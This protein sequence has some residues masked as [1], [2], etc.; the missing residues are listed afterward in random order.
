[1]RR[2]VWATALL[3]VMTGAIAPA[4]AQLPGPTPPLDQRSPA[5]TVRGSAPAERPASILGAP[6]AVRGEP[7]QSPGESLPPSVPGGEPIPAGIP[8]AAGIPEPPV[9]QKPTRAAGLGVPTTAGSAVTT[10]AAPIPAGTIESRVRQAGGAS[11]PVS[12]P[13]NEFLRRPSFKSDPD[14]GEKPP[15][16]PSWKL[17]DR[18]GE[19]LG[20]RGEW[21]R[22]DHAFDG[23]ISPVTNP[24]LFEDPRSLT[25][26]RPIFLS[27]RIPG[28]NPDFSGG[29]ITFFGA[30]ARLA[31]TDRLSFTINKLG[32]VWIGSG[33]N[34]LLSG[35]SGFS[36]LW[37]GPK[38]TFIRNEQTAS[39]LAG[40]LQFQAPIGSGGVYQNTSGLSL[41]PYVS[42]G[43]NLFRDFRFGSFNLLANGGYSFSTTNDRSS[44]MYLSGH[45]DM[46]V[47]NW[48]RIYP[49]VE[50]NWF[51][52]TTDGH[53]TPVG[54]EG[55]DLIN[56]GGQAKGTGLLTGAIGLRGKIT[57]SAQVGFA[58]EAPLAG[59]RDLFDYRFTVD[60]ILRY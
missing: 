15:P 51:L 55:R 36:E 33:G 49:L 41:V 21:F 20:P 2:G 19:L 46:D 31:I 28:S 53:A 58:F 24:F 43:Q 34:A 26:I 35:D 5:R 22:S 27:Q 8:D 40:G 60:F 18:A 39:L 1:M 50:L 16:R 12:D 10:A 23:F 14:T 25:E 11:P 37:F 56:F 48:H 6:V 38:Y 54:I 13:V 47:M 9:V 57:E 42:Y 3:L 32:G 30:Q 7:V 29:H 59:R 52:N 44:Y 17:G 45:M 4:V